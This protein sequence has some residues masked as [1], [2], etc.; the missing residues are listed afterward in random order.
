MIYFLLILRLP[1]FQIRDDEFGEKPAVR[2]VSI[3]VY[4]DCIV[5]AILLGQVIGRW[6]NYFNQ[7]L[8]GSIINDNDSLC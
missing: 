3:W 1:K 5:P 2:R 4:A 6:G 7:E 8:Y